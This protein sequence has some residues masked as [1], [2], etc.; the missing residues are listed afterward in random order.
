MS[1]VD[2]YLK[3]EKA[4][5][6]LENA[7]RRFAAL[8]AENQRLTEELEKYRTWELDN[9]SLKTKQK[10][11]EKHCIYGFSHFCDGEVNRSCAGKEVMPLPRCPKYYNCHIRFDK[12]REVRKG[13]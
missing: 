9:E 4:K 1:Q 13:D 6:A 5:V 7:K 12:L 3:L 8:K 10:T 2:M 11:I